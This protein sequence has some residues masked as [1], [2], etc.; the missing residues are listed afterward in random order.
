M[1]DP[2]QRVILL[3]SG[4]IGSYYG[5][6]LSKTVDV[7]LV[8]IKSHVDSVN[9]G[10]LMVKDLDQGSYYLNAVANLEA[11][12]EECLL[13]LMTKPHESERALS[14]IKNLL[15]DDTIILVLQNGLGKE[16]T[17]KSIVQCEIVRG[18]SM[19]DVEFTS[20]GVV[21]IKFKGDI[22]PKTGQG[23]RIK[24]LLESCGLPV[25][26]TGD[27]DHEIWRKL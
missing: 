2:F 7:L 24:L 8:D 10:G 20:P 27:M 19:T 1:T 5:S 14:E 4:G 9:S 3:C 22:I 12:S 26:L 15:K 13:V 21:D 16:K 11:V 17:V 25:R 18:L 6:Q 23:Q